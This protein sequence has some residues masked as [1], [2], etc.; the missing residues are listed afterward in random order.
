MLRKYEITL[1]FDCDLDDD[2]FDAQIEKISQSVQAHE[3][4]IKKRDMWG[5][6]P[7]G[8]AIKKKEYGTYVCPIPYQ[9]ST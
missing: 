7:L 3:G 2:A 6:R 9:L 1:V 5:R 8:Y 4:E